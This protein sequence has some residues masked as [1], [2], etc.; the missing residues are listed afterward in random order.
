MQNELSESLGNTE[1]YDPNDDPE[2]KK[3]LMNAAIVIFSS[4][5]KL[6]I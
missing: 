4:H 2:L 3:A 1:T 5:M 6:L